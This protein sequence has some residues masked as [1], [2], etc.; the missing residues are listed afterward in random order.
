M[1]TVTLN[2]EGMSKLFPKDDRGPL[3]MRDVARLAGVSTA[4]I[5]RVMH[6]S[7][8]VDPETAARVRAVIQKVNYVPN[9][10]GMALKSGRSGL[11]GLIVPSLS[12]PF[13]SDFVEQFEREIV[14]RDQEMMFAITDHLPEQMQR[15]T[16][17]MLMRGVEGLVILES[18]IETRSYETMLHNQVPFVTLNRLTIEPGVG[19]VAIEA[20]SG[21][22]AAVA[23]LK[24]LGHQR[25]GFLGGIPGL[26]ITREREL[27]FRH[28]MQANR[29]KV[30]E[31]AVLHAGFTIEGGAREMASLLRLAN[32]ITAVL[33]ANDLS[34]IGALRTLGDRGLQ[35][36]K[37]ISV[38]GLD[39]ISLCTMVRPQLTTL[40]LS[41]ESLVKLYLKA[42]TSLIRDP[43][44]PGMQLFYEPELI[45]RETTG[46]V[47]PPGARQAS[48]RRKT[49]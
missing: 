44:E 1:Y 47:H 32:P 11:F 37:H 27:S 15:S 45:L 25:I 8:L 3:K 22:K 20:T 14:N 46:P 49:P 6:N 29:F 39:D 5:S 12:N 7:V 43:H 40:R 33:C 16:R 24:K 10:T 48:G 26:I 41:R 17:R 31:A 35:P 38:V 13:F 18:E 42:L 30:D 21:M 28:A 34:A 2:T 9:N 19:D 4:T 23:H 36:G